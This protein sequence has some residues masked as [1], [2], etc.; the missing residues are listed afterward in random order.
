VIQRMLIDKDGNHGQP[1]VLVLLE[2][3]W[4]KALPHHLKR[5]LRTPLPC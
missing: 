4:L 1:L 3:S 2:C 5:L